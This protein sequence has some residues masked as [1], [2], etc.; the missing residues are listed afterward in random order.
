MGNQLV[1]D[2]PMAQLDSIATIDGVLL[3]DVPPVSK[4]KTDLV[5][6]ATHVDEVQAGTKLPQAYTGQGVIIGL[7]DTGYDYTHPMFK[8]KDGKLRIKAV[9]RPGD[10]T[11]REQ[12][13]SLTDIPVVDEKGKSTVLTLTGE[14]ITN[15]DIILDTLKMKE[16]GGSHGT[17]CAAIAAGRIMDGAD[18]VKGVEG[19]GYLGGMAPEADILL[20]TTASTEE[21]KKKYPNLTGNVLDYNAM[22][23]LYAM[24]RYAAQQNKPLVVSWSQNGHDGFHDGTSTKA[25]YVGNYCKQGNVMALCASNEGDDVMYI[26]RAIN[27]GKTLAIKAV[28][29]AYNCDLY[30]FIKTSKEIKVDLS[31][32]DGKNN[33]VYA[34]NLPLTSAGT[35][36]YEKEFVTG[37]QYDGNEKVWIYTIPYYYT[38]GPQNRLLP[39]I[40]QGNLYLEI[41]KG[42]GLDANDQPFDFVRIN[43]TGRNFD[44]EK[45]A[46]GSYYNFVLS[47][48]SVEE[49][50]TL[51]AWGDEYSQYATTMEEPN[52]FYAG[53]SEYSVG[54]WNTSGEPVTIGAYAAN[55]KRLNDNGELIAATK[56]EVGRYASFSSFG[57][58]FSAQ[59]R[60]YPDV[61]TPGYA[62][63]SA[64]NSFGAKRPAWATK[65]YTKQFKN[66]T[67]PRDYSYVFMS[68]TSMATPAAAGI[69]ALW[70]QAAK[71]KGKTLTNKDIK[72]IIA[73]TSD[74]D[75]F[76][77]DEPLRY[78]AGKMNAY[79][80]LLYVLDLPTAIDGLSQHQPEDVSF[81]LADGTLYTDGAADGTPVSLYNLQGV[82][83][84]KTTVQQGAVSLAALAKGVYAV[85]LGTLGSTLI[86]K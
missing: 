42:T 48:T 28:S 2:V 45:D 38:N 61:A 17:H 80:G 47:V 62:V 37:V 85:Q 65:S 9:Y 55:I 46:S 71:D 73:H 25:R 54:D 52:Y 10:E 69:I 1:V 40:K 53:Q 4:D 74:T 27:K 15:P 29:T 68:G 49:D 11:L 75:A 81:R 82:C 34:C 19:T 32:I 12:G 33:T 50:V 59:K 64:F 60:A 22:Q 78:G 13:E 24:K 63:L 8:D 3:I 76:T 56:E 5:R 84:A 7:I 57:H 23:A 30:A 36:D 16:A 14:F 72:D 26:K 44:T 51:Q 35:N 6:Q 79:K 18:G 86:R 77:K 66:Q 20:S 43:L 39:Y 83:V 41:G 70:V 21:Q 67:E 58:D 31:V